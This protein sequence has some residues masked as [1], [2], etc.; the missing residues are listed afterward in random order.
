MRT[1]KN[2]GYATITHVGMLDW[3]EHESSLVLCQ[4]RLGEQLSSKLSL[5]EFTDY[6]VH[7]SLNRFLRF[8][9]KICFKIK[10]SDDGIRAE[11]LACN[12]LRHVD[13]IDDYG[14]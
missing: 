12:L 13:R 7:L 11:D 10:G 8:F 4:E 3:E 14:L 2:A 1:W 5:F 6:V 9:H